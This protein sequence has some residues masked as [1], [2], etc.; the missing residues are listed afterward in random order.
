MNGDAIAGGCEMASDCS[1][2]TSGA[3]SYQYGAI[4]HGDTLWREVGFW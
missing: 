2:D 3:A 4:S 1:S